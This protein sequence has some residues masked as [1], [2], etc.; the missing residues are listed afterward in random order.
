MVA[1][2]A[3]EVKALREKTGLPMMDCKQALA[4]CQGDAERQDRDGPQQ[5]KLGPAEFPVQVIVGAER[6]FPERPG[7]VDERS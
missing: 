1:I 6:F 2:S 3:A 7:H 4:E 5:D